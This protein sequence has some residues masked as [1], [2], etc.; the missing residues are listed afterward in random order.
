MS[1]KN[2]IQILL[3]AETEEEVRC[4]TIYDIEEHVF[5]FSRMGANAVNLAAGKKNMKF[6]CQYTCIQNNT[7]SLAVRHTN[8]RR[9]T[10]WRYKNK[11][12]LIHKISA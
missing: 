8:R 3:T 9:E 2:I 4:M 12:F 6:G 10:E 5:C 7:K 11:I 1:G